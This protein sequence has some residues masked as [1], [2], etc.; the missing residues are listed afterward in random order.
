MKPIVCLPFCV[1]LLLICFSEVT[2]QRSTKCCLKTSNH[3]V[4][5]HRV[6]DYRI[7]TAGTCPID[8]FVLLTIKG[9]E[10]CCNPKSDWVEEVQTIVDQR[11][12]Q[13]KPTPDPAAL[14]NQNARTGKKKKNGGKGCRQKKQKGPK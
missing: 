6:K 10:I 8:A 13:A 5:I 12:S 14:R 11:K 3:K 4:P 9:R 1:V 2:S 7:Q